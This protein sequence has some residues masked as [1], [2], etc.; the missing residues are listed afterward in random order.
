MKSIDRTILNKKQDQ[1]IVSKGKPYTRDIK[2]GIPVLRD[3]LEGLYWYV[4]HNGELYAS[5]FNKIQGT[6]DRLYINHVLNSNLTASKF[7]ILENN[8]VKYRTASEILSDI[9]GISGLTLTTDSG[10]VSDTSGNADFTVAGGEGIDT[11]ATGTT[12]TI[13]GEDASTSNKGIASFS[14]DN[15]A[16]SSG[17]ITI[18]DGGVDLTAEVTGTLPLANGGIGATS[19]NN[20]ITMGT[21]TTGDY[22]SSLT[23]GNLIDL[24]NNSGESATPT[25]DVDLSEA[26]EAAIADGDYVLFLDGG[27]TGATKKEA[28]H[29]VATLFSGSGLTATNSVIAVDTL[30]QDTTG[31]AATATLASTCTVTDNSDTANKPIVLHGGSNA[32]Q[33]D[34]AQ[35]SF[36][37]GNSILLV[38]KV[39]L[40]SN[41]IQNSAG[42]DTITIDTDQNV[43]VAGALKLG[44]GG[45]IQANDGGTSITVGDDDTATFAGSIVGEKDAT[46]TGTTLTSC[47]S[48]D[49]LISATQTL[50]QSV[51]GVGTQ[52]YRMIKT[53]L[54]ETAAGGWDN[55]YLIDQ[56][57]GGS[58]KFKVDNAGNATF[59]GTVTANSVTLGKFHVMGQYEVYGRYSSVN[60]WYVGNQ[61]FGT[62]VAEGDWSGIG[63]FKMNYAQFTAVSNVKLIGWKFVGSFSSSVDYEME[64][65]HTETDSDG[66]SDPAEATKVGSTQSVS[67]TASRI[68]SLGETGLTYSVPAGDQ[69]YVLTRYTSGSGTKNSY[70]TVAFEFS[71]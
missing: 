41:I 28:L 16:A 10:S 36:N 13:A 42:E 48:D 52:E 50:N 9:G 70:G 60:T 32:L 65:W 19:L 34:S 22:V 6:A 21:H 45:L 20:L 14:S 31:N 5:K 38:P 54:T 68:Y 35:F 61:S 4:K 27:A 39:K 57:V 37:P 59:N 26:S 33:D 18:K 29:D 51:G 63:F 55:V 11:S 47:S 53:N 12:V 17:A 15:F 30:N 49:K 69:L 71:Y 7:L 44:S 8:E 24:Q 67:P 2:E 1:I 40:S 46:I 58:S 62:S 56:Q 43:A 25:I 66:N 23:A 3:T 64:V